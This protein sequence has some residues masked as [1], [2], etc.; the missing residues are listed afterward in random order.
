MQ[1]QDQR[2]LMEFDRLE[3]SLNGMASS[4]IHKLR[5]EAIA[6]FSELGFPTTRLEEWRFTN[7][8]PVS[9]TPFEPVLQYDP[10]GVTAEVVNRYSLGDSVGGLL[11]FING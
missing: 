6:R 7:V 8:A 9:R 4:P 5:K 11:V 10:A 2:Y 1:Q 3:K